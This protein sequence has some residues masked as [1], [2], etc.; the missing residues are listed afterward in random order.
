MAAWRFLASL[1]TGIENCYNNTTL[2]MFQFIITLYKAKCI[3]L[4]V[5]FLAISEAEASTLPAKKKFFYVPFTAQL[6][7]AVPNYLAWHA[8]VHLF[9]ISLKNTITCVISIPLVFIWH[10]K[11]TLFLSSSFL[12]INEL[13]G[14]HF[15]PWHLKRSFIVSPIL[16]VNTQAPVL[17][18]HIFSACKAHTSTIQEAE[19]SCSETTMNQLFLLV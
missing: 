1:K 10:S 17:L 19:S 16:S 2:T 7:P 14:R 11:G 13:P 18:L 9:K 3:Y 12:W 6:R 15:Q 5:S 8:F 4:I